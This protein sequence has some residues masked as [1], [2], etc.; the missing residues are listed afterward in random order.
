M[1]IYSGFNEEWK[2]PITTN[3]FKIT[4]LKWYE[5][6]LASS[7]EILC[8]KEDA[9]VTD[10][11]PYGTISQW[12]YSNGN[13]FS[14]YKATIAIQVQSYTSRYLT[15]VQVSAVFFEMNNAACSQA[16]FHVRSIE[17]L[18]LFIYTYLGFTKSCSLNNTFIQTLD[19]LS[20]NPNTA[21]SSNPEIQTIPFTLC[22]SFK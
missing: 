12:F 2:A 20:I 4:H 5:L 19:Y 10:E 21:I 14:C 11:V 8:C 22:S 15:S 13:F 1:H 9:S 3:K 6:V 18:E 17:L 7:Q 16:N